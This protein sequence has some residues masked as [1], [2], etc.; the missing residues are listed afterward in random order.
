M[1]SKRRILIIGLGVVGPSSILAKAAWAAS[2]APL[3][4]DDVISLQKA[5][6]GD[7]LISAKIKQAASVNFQLDAKT[8][9]SL[10]EQGVSA[11]VIKAML[12]RATP[13]TAAPPIA[14]ASSPFGRTLIQT[15]S[16][17]TKGG[18]LA[19][20]PHPGRVNV[21]GF[22]FVQIPHMDVA[23]AH[24]LV[25]TTDPGLSI[26]IGSERDPSSTNEFAL[27]KMDVDE[28]TKER[29][30]VLGRRSRFSTSGGL[31]PDKDYLIP[32]TSQP[33]NSGMFRV[34]PSAPLAQGEYAVLAGIGQ[35]FDF[36]VD[37]S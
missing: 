5:G 33:A 9:V 15:V 1:R 4:N 2:D 18:D 11:P 10:R 25:R 6:L 13:Q 35:V 27:V 21:S 32:F 24:S 36:G 12:E 19:L 23:G 31:T 14:M 17:S 20:V 28:S 8:L 7:D 37:A 29:S 3:T 26:V 16:L 34:V 22:A 30:F